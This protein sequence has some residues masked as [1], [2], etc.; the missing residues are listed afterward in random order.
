MMK[1]YNNNFKNS[2]GC[3]KPV[4]DA[5]DPFSKAKAACSSNGGMLS[6]VHDDEKNHFVQKSKGFRIAEVA[7]ELLENAI[8]FSYGD[9]Q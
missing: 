1:K 6:T 5:R 8:H 7:L 9:V 2:G 4:P 3:Y